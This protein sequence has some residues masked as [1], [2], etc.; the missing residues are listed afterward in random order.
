M[1]SIS[2]HPPDASPYRWVFGSTRASGRAPVRRIWMPVPALTTT[3]PSPSNPASERSSATSAAAVSAAPV[4]TG[5]SSPPSSPRDTHDRVARRRVRQLTTGDAGE[6]DCASRPVVGHHVPEQRGGGVAAVT[7][8]ITRSQLPAQ[9][10]LGAGHQGIA[11]Q[12]GL[13]VAQPGEQRTRHPRHQRVRERAPDLRRQVVPLAHDGSRAPVRPQHRRS[14]RLPVV[15]GEHHAVHLPTEPDG[16]H[17]RPRMT[18]AGRLCE[19]ADAAVE[20]PAPVLG[21]DLRVPRLR[22]LKLVGLLGLGDHGAVA[23]RPGSASG[24]WCPGRSR[25][26]CLRKP[27]SC[28]LQS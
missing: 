1:A 18:A 27:R 24:R 13:V 17:G 26:R 4:T 22:R 16:G 28:R 2:Y 6:L 14:Q 10:V 5:T 23:C 12:G 21:V 20:R 11:Q 15:A 8:G 25:G 19:P 3:P 9:P 7:R